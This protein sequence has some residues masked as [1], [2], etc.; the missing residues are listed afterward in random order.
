MVND[1]IERAC[2][3]FFNFNIN[4]AK[5]LNK[6]EALKWGTCFLQTLCPIAMPKLPLEI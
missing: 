5:A 2:A 4:M 1:G 3:S 6:K